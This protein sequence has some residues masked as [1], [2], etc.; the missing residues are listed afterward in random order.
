MFISSTDTQTKHLDLDLNSLRLALS[1]IYQ[2][3]LPVW[4][5]LFMRRLLSLRPGPE[6]E[7]DDGQSQAGLPSPAGSSA[8]RCSRVA[9][10]NVGNA[11]IGA[12]QLIGLADPIPCLRES[13]VHSLH[14]PERSRCPHISAEPLQCV[15]RS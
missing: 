6:V 9:H 5:S 15:D 13:A 1:L 3:L 2:A 12:C 7:E 11:T 14:L 8:P 4:P 10:A